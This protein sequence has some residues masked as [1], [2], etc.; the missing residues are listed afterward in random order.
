MILIYLIQ[1]SMPLGP[2]AAAQLA[3]GQ[4]MGARAA[5][6]MF[7]NLAYAALGKS[8][9]KAASDARCLCPSGMA[10]RCAG[11]PCTQPSAWPRSARPLRWSV[12]L[13][14]RD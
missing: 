10:G 9:A 13:G 6:P 2:E 5:L 8:G 3:T 1:N 7:Q 12:F 14:T 11:H 4:R